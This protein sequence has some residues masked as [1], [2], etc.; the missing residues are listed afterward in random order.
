MPPT[1]QSSY[2][3]MATAVL[4]AIVSMVP[5]TFISRTNEESTS[6]AFGVAV[7]Q[8]SEDMGVI[9]YSDNV[10]GI[11]VRERS[12]SAETPNSVGPSETARLLTKGALWVTAEVQVAAGD[13][14]TVIAGG[15]F[16][17]TGGTALP[18]ARWDTS[19]SGAGQ[20]AVLRLG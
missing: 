3:N 14:V 5:A 11:T 13:A 2:G 6:L 10:V 9:D 8:G 4:G 20:L 7:S 16:S 18:G 12:S 17:N 19:T 1:I 15:L